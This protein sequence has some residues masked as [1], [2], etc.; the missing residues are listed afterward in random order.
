LARDKG[1]RKRLG[2]IQI[3]MGCYHGFIDE[4]FPKAFEALDEALSIAGEE[5]DIITLILA[6]FWLGILRAYD[7]DFEKARSSLQTAVDF[8]VAANSLWGI[9][10]MKAQLAYFGNYWAGDMNSLAG[11]SSEALR[12]AE[13]SGDP[14]SRGVSHI[15]YGMSCYVKGHLEDAQHHLLEGT[16]LCGRVGLYGWDANANASLGETYI[17]MKDYLKARESIDHSLRIFEAAQIQPSWAR[18]GQV[19]KTMCDVMLGDRDVN[20][21]SLRALYGRNRVKAADGWTCRVLGE[22]FLNVGDSHVVEAEH[23]IQQ[24]IEADERNGMRFHLGRDFALYGELFIF[25]KDRAKAQ[26]NLGKAIE[27]LKECGA[28][29]F[30]RK[31]EEEIAKLT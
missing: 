26:Q 5:W 24:A 10:V 16:N 1:Y 4:N 11:L 21:E 19:A 17:E 3:I 25:Q 8:N 29:G 20:L 14:I 31:Y 13:E 27:I 15:S 30:V 23:W 18:L 7:C 28:D 2:Q 22:I 9:A 6:S 12:I